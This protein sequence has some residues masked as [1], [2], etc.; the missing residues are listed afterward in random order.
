MRSWRRPQARGPIRA[1]S[2]NSNNCAYY[3]LGQVLALARRRRDRDREAQRKNLFAPL[4]ITRIR[5]ARSLLADQP[6]DEARYRACVIGAGHIAHPLPVAPSM[7]SDAHPLVPLGYGH[8]QIELHEGDG[9]MSAA[10]PD[11]AR[12]I[13]IMISR[14]D[15]PALRGD[16]IQQMLSNAATR[17]G[18]GFD[19]ARD[20][21]DGSHF[22]FK[23]GALASSWSL[24]QLDGDFGFCV[25]WSGGV[26]PDHFRW[27]PTL[28]TV[29]RE[30]RRARWGEDLFPH[31]GMLSLA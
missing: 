8:E 20:R 25:V 22:C 16:T 13:A 12:L 23:G 24:L 5:Q 28:P 4:G 7:M 17:H 11:L 3:L 2:T 6:P 15:N 19:V 10:M 31:F 1:R 30:A 27:S 26:P 29:M 21:G 9:G 14:R 18:H